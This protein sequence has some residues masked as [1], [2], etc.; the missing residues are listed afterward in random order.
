MILQF[1]RYT[2]IVGIK[3]RKCLLSKLTIYLCLSIIESKPIPPQNCINVTAKFN[4]C[5]G[6]EGHEAYL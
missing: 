1:E 2:Q 3:T 4:S 6:K 5:Q